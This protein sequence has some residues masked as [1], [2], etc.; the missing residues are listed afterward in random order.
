[1]FGIKKV[2]LGIL[3]MAIGLGTGV[4]GQL[5]GDAQSRPAAATSEAPL[6]LQTVTLMYVPAADAARIINDVSEAQRELGDSRY[7]VKAVAETRMNQVVLVGRPDAMELARTLITDLDRTPLT[8]GEFFIYP[9]K[10][11]QAEDVRNILKRFFETAWRNSYDLEPDAEFGDWCVADTTRN[12]LLIQVSL[13]FEEQMRDIIE[14]LDRPVPE[15]RVMLTIM[16]V[17]LAPDGS[18]AGLPGEL[19]GFTRTRAGV[20][21]ST[22]AAFRNLLREEGRLLGETRFEVL[23]QHGSQARLRLGEGMMGVLPQ[24]NPDGEVTLQVDSPDL[25]MRVAVR[26]GETAVL[27]ELPL[28]QGNARLMLLGAT[29]IQP[30]ATRPRR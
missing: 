21:G 24:V 29:L 30:P 22:M 3:M 15:V 8:H 17:K 27:G 10:R 25:S 4:W 23:A 5:A 14:K 12:S 26:N 28:G 1:M 9:L 18:V 11:A 20:D 16:E 19:Q 2:A 13:K 6:G 7:G